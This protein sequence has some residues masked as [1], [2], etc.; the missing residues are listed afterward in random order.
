[1]RF[2]PIGDARLD[3]AVTSVV[4]LLH[5]ELILLFGSRARGDAHADSDYDVMIVVSDVAA[6]TD[7]IKMASEV[8][9]SAHLATDVLGRSVEEYEHRQDDP[10]FL[11]YMIARE[12]LVL[13]T[14]GRIPQRHGRPRRAREQPIEGLR[15]WVRRAESDL[16]DAENSLASAEPVW[17]AICFHS[18][19]CVEKLLKALIVNRGTFPPRTHEL[20]DLLGKQPPE[21]RDDSRL[22]ATCRL[23]QDLYPKSR[24]PELPE[25]TPEEARDAIAGARAARALLLPLLPL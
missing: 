4:D 19:A 25:P 7:A 3:E 1:M 15:M 14:S 16:R 20:P 5:P 10:G 23:L 17:D 11:D 13:F 22:V 9:R 24:Y 21:I 2:R 18:H 6:V 8:F 12:G